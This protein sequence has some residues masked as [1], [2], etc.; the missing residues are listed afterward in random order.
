M[1]APPGKT[2]NV[3]GIDLRILISETASWRVIGRVMSSISES[4]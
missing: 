3:E 1:Y 2:V 4:D